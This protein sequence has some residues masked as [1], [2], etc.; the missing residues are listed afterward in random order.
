MSTFIHTFATRCFSNPY[1]LLSITALC[2]AGNF[3]V[4]RAIYQEVPPVALA[5]IRWV[6]AFL[7][8]LPFAYKHLVRD[9]ATIKKHWLIMIT[10]GGI[11]IGSF[12][13]LVYTG[14]NYTTAINGVI[15]NSSS[16]V[17]MAIMAFL[18]FKERISRFQTSGILLSIAGVLI[19]VSR[20]DIASL[21][22]LSLNIGD[23]YILAAFVIWAF[24]TVMLRL[25]PDIHNLS[26]L[27][28]SFLLA[29]IANMPF[30]LLE[31]WAGRNVQL[32]PQSIS[33]LIYVIIFPSLIAYL[34]YNRGI[35]LIGAN[36]GGAFLHV[37]PLFGALMAVF[38][39]GERLE[40][41]HIMGFVAIIT[42]VVMTT[43]KPSSAS[44]T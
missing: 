36:R 30:M 13:T 26:L 2:W 16:P 24:Y 35:E 34:F 10:L 29:A 23:L 41:F 21:G 39:L 12:N 20:G 22:N 6:G 11:G 37:V 14:V 31:M 17:F 8:I 9:W 42:G 43:R 25:R 15:M 19:V 18:L 28:M 40:P 27:A 5:T 4:G 3:I 1:L 33:G 38:F 7:V 44:N 32:S